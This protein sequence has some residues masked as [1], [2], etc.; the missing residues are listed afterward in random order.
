[1]IETYVMDNQEIESE[2]FVLTFPRIIRF[3]PGQVVSIKIDGNQPRL[4]SIA[5]GNNE[6]ELK[7]LYDVKPDGLVTP[8]LKKLQK[9]DRISVS[10]AFGDFIDDET[11]AYWI[12]A[13]TGIAPFYAMFKSG[14]GEKKILIHGG[15][16]K[17]SFYFQYEF[18]SFFKENYIRCCSQNMDRSLY[19]GRVTQ[20][21]AE[22]K[23]L[24]PDQKYYLCGSA[25]MVVETR[26]I[27]ISKKIPFANIF[28]EIYF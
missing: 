16:N 21:L 6:E 19:H 1:M 8:L 11:P 20:Y 4:Y 14:L 17:N 27:L 2:V 5:S 15:R 24:P 25:E 22:Q 9:G 26:D 10:E 23:F 18:I 3:Q 28:A 12:A 7:I 13:G